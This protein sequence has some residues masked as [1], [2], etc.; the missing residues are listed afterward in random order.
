MESIQPKG[1][2]RNITEQVCFLCCT[3]SDFGKTLSTAAAKIRGKSAAW[4]I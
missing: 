3:D 4:G 1:A 2:Q